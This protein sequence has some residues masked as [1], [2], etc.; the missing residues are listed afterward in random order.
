VAYRYLDRRCLMKRIGFVVVL[1]LIIVSGG[2]FVACGGGG[3]SKVVKL[4]GTTVGHDDVGFSYLVQLSPD[5]GAFM[6]TI[7]SMGHYI[8]GLEYDPVSDTLFGTTSTMDPNFPNGLIEIDMMTAATTTIGSAG[9]KINNPT[10]N[11]SGDM[12]GWSEDGDQPITI[13]PSTGVATTLG[14]NA[15]DVESWRHGLAFD[16]ADTLYIVNG[17]EGDIWTIDTGDGS[18]TFDTTI[19]AIAHHGDFHPTSGMYWGVDQ[20]YDRYGGPSSPARNLLVVDINTP[21]IMDSLAT[22][23]NL[24]AITFY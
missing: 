24:H 18:A 15:G 16:N 4:F 22:V 20:Y 21:A 7:G 17:D 5:T 10:V 3:S 12:Y 19:G 8:N 14:S 23:D 13:D 2:L 9:M 11:S 1:S 6:G